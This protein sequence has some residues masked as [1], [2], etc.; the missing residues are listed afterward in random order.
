M[1]RQM[2]LLAHFLYHKQKPPD[3]D[4]EWNVKGRELYNPYWIT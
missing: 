1:W 3:M 2:N 4:I